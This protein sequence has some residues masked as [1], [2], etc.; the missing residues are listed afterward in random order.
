MTAHSENIQ[1]ECAENCGNSPK[2]RLL[3]D[4]TIAFAKSDIR[5]CVDC[6]AD[7]VVWHIVGDK[8]IRGKGDFETA[9]NQMKDR[10]AQQMHIHNIITHGNTGSVN[11]TL[12]LNDKQSVAF[13]DVYNFKGFGKNSKIK[14]ITSYVV[15]TS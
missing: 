15:K 8:R 4:L 2:K 5:F 3:K 9:L 12:I 6:V 13:C 11:G 1:V 14:L 10:E 7:D